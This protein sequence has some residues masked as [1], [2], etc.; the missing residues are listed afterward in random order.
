LLVGLQIPIGWVALRLLTGPAEVESLTHSYFAIRIWGAPA[1][2]AMFAIL[3]TFI[4]LGQSRRLLRT[5]LLLNGLN[6][7]L[8][9]LF[10]GTLG[11]GVRGIAL[12]TVIAEW[13]TLVYA[14]RV[15]SRLLH[16]HHADA[17]AFWPHWRIFDH[18]V[19]LRT[20]SANA[21]IMIRT[22]FLLLGFGWFTNLGARVGIEVLA[23]NH[24]LLQ[25][26]TTSAY[27]LDGYAN[28][29][30]TFVGRAIGARRRATFD[31]AVRAATSL[32]AW[33]AVIAAGVVL[34]FGGLAIRSLTEHEAVQQIAVRFLPLAAL[35]VMLSFAA[36]QLDGIF[37]GATHT[38]EMRNASIVSFAV[39][40]LACWLLV[41][42][43]DNLG[44]WVAFE[45]YIVARSVTLA[46]QFPALRQT[47]S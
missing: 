29:T 4:G 22:L 13:T 28:A 41:P 20:L 25:F 1:S 8:D 2:L 16:E 10:A 11:W 7:S 24:I 38:R 17:E 14:L 30:E 37:I 26:I 42:R 9:L 44:L 40:L 18:R 23:A 47:I 21:D 31:A 15:V 35:Y 27:M 36:F 12:G 32:A 33:T 43:A 46:M 3:G 19:A 34:L 45:I 5:Q 6:I 39:F